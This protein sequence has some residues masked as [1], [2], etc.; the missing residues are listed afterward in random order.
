LTA[1]LARLSVVAGCLVAL[2]AFPRA[3]AL[4]EAELDDDPG[5]PP[6]VFYFVARPPTINVGSYTLAYFGVCGLPPD[7]GL[8][9]L[10]VSY[11]P[12]DSVTPATRRT[13]ESRETCPSGTRFFR[14]AVPAGPFTRVGTYTFKITVRNEHGADEA[15]T[16]L[17]VVQPNRAPNARDDT[18]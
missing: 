10:V 9:N 1:Y 3:V 8:D 13:Y 11:S 16:L 17:T 12:G 18:A 2:D 14:A 5:T 7:S 6:Q 4:A 15:R